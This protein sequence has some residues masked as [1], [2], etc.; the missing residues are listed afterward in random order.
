MNVRGYKTD[1]RETLY[2]KVKEKNSYKWISSILRFFIT[3]SLN[4]NCDLKKLDPFNANSSRFL[5]Y[6]VKKKK[7][8][9]LSLLG[10]ITQL[11]KEKNNT[12]QEPWDD[13]TEYNFRK[14][15][16]EE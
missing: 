16:R 15:L 2:L 11:Q 8:I 7:M 6:L 12:K 14:V 5:F 4:V 10:D 9:P 13:N 3:K 1:F